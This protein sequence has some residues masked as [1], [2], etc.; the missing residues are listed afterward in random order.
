MKKITIHTDGGCSGNPG[1]GGWA[2]VLQ[3]GTNRKEL[4]GSAL[5]TTNNRMELTAAA[6]A[7]KALKEPC[8]VAVFTDSEYVRDGITQWIHSWRAKGWK[9]KIKNMDLWQEL[10]AAVSR[11][12]VEWHWVRGHA[13]DEFN[14][15]CD[16]LATQEIERLKTKHTAAE[17][18]AACDQFLVERNSIP[19]QPELLELDPPMLL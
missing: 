5:A 12:K 14:E 19:G 3:C 17:L 10:D 18:K 16:F 1:P 6:E 2:A 7:L 8:E 15:R 13:G 11:H 4:S 9:K